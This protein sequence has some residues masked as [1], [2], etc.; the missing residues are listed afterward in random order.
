MINHPAREG[1][2]FFGDDVRSAAKP[3]G[4]FHKLRGID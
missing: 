1:L 2:P 4:I 3:G